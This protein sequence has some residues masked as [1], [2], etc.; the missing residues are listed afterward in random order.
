[1]EQIGKNREPCSN[2]TDWDPSHS[3]AITPRR[4]RAPGGKSPAVAGALPLCGRR[5]CD[6]RFR[7]CR[8]PFL[9]PLR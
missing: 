1:M 2:P 3:N 9:T 8:R 5:L 7:K 4:S 6:G